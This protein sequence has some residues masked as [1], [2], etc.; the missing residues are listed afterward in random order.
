MWEHPPAL[1]PAIRE[2]IGAWLVCLVVAAGCFTLL[3]AAAPVPDGPA[4]ID[5]PRPGRYGGRRRSR[6]RRS[7]STREML[8]CRTTP[9]DPVSTS[10][11]CRA[12][13]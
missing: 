11:A 6:S 4:S 3:A 1:G 7:S 8:K 10:R 9:A 2:V 12:G 13:T 5:R